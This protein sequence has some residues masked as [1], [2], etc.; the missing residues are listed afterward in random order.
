MG[1][2]ILILEEVIYPSRLRKFNFF[3]LRAAGGGRAVENR[4]VTTWWRI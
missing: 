2:G 3:E 1:D 4:M